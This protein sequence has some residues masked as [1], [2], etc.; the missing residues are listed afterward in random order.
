MPVCN[1]SSYEV[2]VE[3]GTYTITERAITIKAADKTEDFRPD[4]SLTG[5]SFEVT[6]G[7]LAGGD[8]VA[9]LVYT[10]SQ[11]TVGSSA[12]VPSDAVIKK[13]SK[14]VTANY[15]IT[16]S[17]GTLTVGKGVQEILAENLTLT[18]DGASHS[19]DEIQRRLKY[20]D[21]VTITTSAASTTITEPGSI[22]VTFAVPAFLL[23][24]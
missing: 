24:L 1:N 18:Y 17:N 8:V 7:S 14:D 5:D 3:N 19:I 15:I 6:S 9:A 10:G 12:V 2:T 20:E 4:L 16:Y 23:S 21:T 11:N 13:G 22:V